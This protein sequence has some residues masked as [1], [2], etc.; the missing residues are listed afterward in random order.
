MF[1]VCWSPSK[2]AFVVTPLVVFKGENVIPVEYDH[3][4][5]IKPIIRF[6]SN[7]W[8]DENE[9]ER[10]LEDM[11]QRLRPSPSEPII[12]IIDSAR[13]HDTLRIR[14]CARANN[15][16]L[17]FVPPGLTS[18]LQVPDLSVFKTLRD[19]IDREMKR[20]DRLNASHERLLSAVAIAVQKAANEISPDL[21]LS[22]YRHSGVMRAVTWAPSSWGNRDENPIEFSD[23]SISTSILPRQKWPPP[24]RPTAASKKR[25]RDTPSGSRVEPKPGKYQHS[26]RRRRNMD[27]TPSTDAAQNEAVLNAT[28]DGPRQEANPQVIRHDASSIDDPEFDPFQPDT[29]PQL[30]T[31]GKPARV[32]E[33]AE[34]ADDSGVIIALNTM[35]LTDKPI[36][37]STI[38]GIRSSE[39]KSNPPSPSTYHFRLSRRP[40][41]ALRDTIV[42]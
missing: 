3:T 39:R 13:Q 30:K 20:F 15:F 8:T 14:E 21:I 6:T 1:T 22:G 40:P 12:M 10:W 28:K 24:V 9:V 32:F 33:D 19:Y 11:C 41:A 18:L 42:S 29:S 31:R 2:V 38:L 5:Y 25:A 36:S 7:G 23:A 17:I 16:I 26:K 4:A 34:N 37:R 35:P 27:Q